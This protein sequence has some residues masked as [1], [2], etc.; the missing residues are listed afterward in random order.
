MKRTIAIA[1]V[2]ASALA[3]TGNASA[4]QAMVRATVPFDFSLNNKLL[5]AGEYTITA[6]SAHALLVQNQAKHAAAFTSTYSD[7]KQS[8]DSV[9]VFKRYGNQYFLNAV[10]GSTWSSMNV[11]IPQSKRE[12]RALRQEAAVRQTGAMEGGQLDSGEMLVA[13]K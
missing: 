9:L 7:G 13:L 12:Q 8:K 3:A 2:A 1:L 10:R 4:Q 5:P 6:A 11:A